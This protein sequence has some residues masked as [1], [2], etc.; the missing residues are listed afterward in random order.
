MKLTNLKLTNFRNFSKYDIDFDKLNIIS[1]PNGKGKTNILEAIYLLSATKSFRHAKN[2]DLVLWG[3]D[4]ARIASKITS[5]EKK[6]KLD[7]VVDLRPERIQPKTIKIDDQK[8]K[9]FFIIGKLKT[10]LFS[11]ESLDIILGSPFI[12]RRFLDFLISQQ[13]TKYA[14]YLLY[15]S[16]ILKN[17]NLVLFR[18]NQRQASKDE[19][20]FW[21]QELVD[22]GS[23]IIFRRSQLIKYFNKILSEKYQDISNKK[24][25]LYLEYKNKIKGKSIE[26][27]KKSFKDQ[28]K[29]IQNKEIIMQKTLLGPQRDNLLFKINEKNLEFFGSR[30]EI[31]TA[32]LA[33]KLAEIEFLT[34][35]SDG[36]APLFLLDDVFSELDEDRKEYLSQQLENTQSILTSCDLRTIPAKL[37]EKAR[38]IKI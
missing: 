16:R 5:A 20:D 2:S 22:Y 14:K 37:R 11:P 29:L 19:L 31:R 24:Q 15:L 32:I 8:R 1:G 9:L 38:M 4:F 36:D 10:V 28:L 17:R 25:E 26:E 13:E 34:Q 21:N 23:F 35:K 7:F 33:L 3:K 12:R 27:I 18:I 30:G 6:F